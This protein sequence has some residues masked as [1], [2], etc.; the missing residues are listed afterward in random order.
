[1]SDAR[2]LARRT[3]EKSGS[4]LHQKLDALYQL[5]M[6]AA[7]ER[8]ALKVDVNSNPLAWV[9]AKWRIRVAVF[10]ATWAAAVTIV[11]LDQIA[12]RLQSWGIIP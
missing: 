9:P 8:A 11:S 2:D 1:M 4:T 10:A 5:D 6:M 7:D 12:A 3:F